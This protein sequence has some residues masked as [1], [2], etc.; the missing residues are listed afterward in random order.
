MPAV[1]AK[2]QIRGP[3]NFLTRLSAHP[4]IVNGFS[5]ETLGCPG[6][7]ELIISAE[8]PMLRGGWVVQTST[9]DEISLIHLGDISRK[10]HSI[11]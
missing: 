9:Y 4:F 3:P 8:I 2:S 5:P 1:Q 11:A 7:L 10:S 6:I